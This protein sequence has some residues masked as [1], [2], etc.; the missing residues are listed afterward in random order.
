MEVTV[1][2]SPPSSAASDPHWLME[3]TTLIGPV[4][5]GTFCL[6]FGSVWVV[7][8]PQAAEASSMTAPRPAAASFVSRV[9]RIPMACLLR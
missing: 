1:T 3:A 4:G 5:S 2:S 9:I 6:V 8:E 7:A